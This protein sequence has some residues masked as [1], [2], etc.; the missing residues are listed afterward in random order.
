VRRL[1]DIRNILGARPG[2]ERTNRRKRSV[3]HAFDK[4][5]ARKRMCTRTSGDAEQLP[6]DAEHTSGDAAE[7]MSVEALLRAAKDELR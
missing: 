7:S 4:N 5:P 3:S 1:S 6:E 2:F